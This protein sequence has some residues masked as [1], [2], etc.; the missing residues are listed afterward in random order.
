MS[1][2]SSRYEKIESRRKFK[3]NSQA[4][5]TSTNINNRTN[6]LIPSNDNLSYNDIQIN[7]QYIHYVKHSS[8]NDVSFRNDHKN[9]KLNQKIVIE[10]PSNIN[11][12]PP[13]S[14]YRTITHSNSPLK[15]ERV[16]ISNIRKAFFNL[17]RR[18]TFNITPIK[19]RVKSPQVMG[20][21][22]KIIKYT[23]Q[24]KKD[25]HSSNSSCAKK[26]ERIIISTLPR[27]IIDISNSDTRSHGLNITYNNDEIINIYLKLKSKNTKINPSMINELKMLRDEIDDFIKKY[28][29]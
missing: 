1:S 3:H 16:N 8:K 14:A 22:D 19:R 7:K 15:N 26:N 21:K 11:S 2:N 25:C 20:I 17:N 4:S 29:S 6:S 9:T 27:A 18:S 12:K 5:S 23:S 28:N 10:I 13:N 24:I